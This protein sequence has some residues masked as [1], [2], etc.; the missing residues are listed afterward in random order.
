MVKFLKRV[1]RKRSDLTDKQL[2]AS[3]CVHRS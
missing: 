3:C 2:L 1:F